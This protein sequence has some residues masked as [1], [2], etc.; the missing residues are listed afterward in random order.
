M[1]GAAPDPHTH[2]THPPA[3]P[4]PSTGPREGRGSSSG[5]PPAG[6]EAGG[7]HGRGGM[8]ATRTRRKAAAAEAA[9][10]A[11]GRPAWEGPGNV[12]AVRAA[13]AGFAAAWGAL[14]LLHWVRANPG[15]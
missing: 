11:A 6:G 15:W 4:Q 12:A 8:A 10:A 3:H 1:G 13:G 14:L 5:P 2:C 9:P 7:A